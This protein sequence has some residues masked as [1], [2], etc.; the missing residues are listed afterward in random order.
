MH[1]LVSHCVPLFLLDR[2]SGF[3]TDP[4]G[5]HLDVARVALGVRD[6][7]LQVLRPISDLD[8]LKC[9]PDLAFLQQICSINDVPK[10]CISAIKQVG[11]CGSQF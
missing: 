5:E 6:G 9:V 1:H 7:E 2:N 3:K 8:V 11:S 4:L 10:D